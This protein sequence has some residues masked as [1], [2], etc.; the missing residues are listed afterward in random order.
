MTNEAKLPKTQAATLAKM[1]EI[2]ANG[3]PAV[4]GGVQRDGIHLNALAPLRKKGFIKFI[5]VDGFTRYEAV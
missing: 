3:E 1:R 4:A 2:K 5:E